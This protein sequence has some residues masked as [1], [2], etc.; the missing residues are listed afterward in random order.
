[1]GHLK[2]SLEDLTFFL[3][4]FT[5]FV[6]TL[7]TLTLVPSLNFIEGCDSVASGIWGV[8]KKLVR[9]PALRLAQN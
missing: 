8:V 1:M 2:I 4:S 3:L 6:Q 7:R 5:F 9:G